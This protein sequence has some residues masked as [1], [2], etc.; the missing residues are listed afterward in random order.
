MNGPAEARCL[1]GQT[2]SSNFGVGDVGTWPFPK[3]SKHPWH[4][5]DGGHHPQSSS[6]EGMAEDHSAHYPGK[7]EDFHIPS[8]HQNPLN[9]IHGFS[10]TNDCR[11]RSVVLGA[12]H[13]AHSW[14]IILA[15]GV[16][17]A[18]GARR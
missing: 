9:H 12:E 5:E 11:A 13:R 10:S 6:S 2:F 3:S 14:C 1:K 7:G 18:Y 8:V 4:P 15:H 17:V 16:G